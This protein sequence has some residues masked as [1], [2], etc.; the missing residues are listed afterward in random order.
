MEITF[1]L[2]IKHFD[3]EG[4]TM[5]LVNIDDIIV[6]KNDPKEKKK[7]LNNVLQRSLNIGFKQ[8]KVLF[9]N[10]SGIIKR[11]HFCITTQIC[12]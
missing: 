10:E 2:F 7:Y 8:I 12:P 5:L 11:G 6:I 9:G 4:V 3:L 1:N